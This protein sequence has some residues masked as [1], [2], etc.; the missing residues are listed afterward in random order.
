MVIK[1]VHGTVNLVAMYILNYCSIE[2]AKLS[3]LAM[4]IAELQS[5]DI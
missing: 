2:T 4:V 1:E 5:V 3:R